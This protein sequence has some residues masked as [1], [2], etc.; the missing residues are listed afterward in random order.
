MAEIYTRKRY[1]WQGAPSAAERRRR[2]PLPYGEK[3][4][5]K[6]GG[7]IGSM[8]DF[9][10]SFDGIA[11][12]A[13]NIPL[14]RNFFDGSYP[15]VAPLTHPLHFWA[16]VDNSREV[17]ELHTHPYVQIW[18]VKSG[19]YEHFFRDRSFVLGK[20]SMIIVPPNFPHYLDTRGDSV[21]LRCEFT[22]DFIADIPD[23]S[24]KNIM[25]NT[26]YLEPVLVNSNKI[27]PYH[28]FSEAAAQEIEDVFDVLCNEFKKKDAFSAMFVRSNIIRL[29]AIIA[30][31]YNI[32]NHD[33]QLAIY[34]ESLNNALTYIHSHFTE[35][36]LLE[37][38]CKTAMLGKTTFSYL[39]KHI[40]GVSF[41]QYVQ[42]L[43]IFH[44]QELLVSTDRTQ[45]D[46]ASACGFNGISFFHR[47][48]KQFT[49]MLPGQYRKQFSKKDEK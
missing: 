38:M 11:R 43:R 8:T 13:G 29:L 42:Y 45:E 44:A 15:P 23:K 32:Y 33:K 5:F 4:I 35:R 28:Y 19:T 41:S 49:G 1:P 24:L 9:I 16:A 31:E 39:F 7:G 27:E 14:E 26:I 20:G 47:V 30:R 12:G 40:M 46:I 3:Y 2:N 17:D 21:L 48:F 22:D 37:D 25:F 18:Y 34:R 10:T 6:K 36:L